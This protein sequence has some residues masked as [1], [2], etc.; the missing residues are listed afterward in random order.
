M[1][2]LY[3]TAIAVAAALTL[4]GCTSTAAVDRDGAAGA[5]TAERS[6]EDGSASGAQ[7]TAAA[8]ESDGTGAAAD[9]AQSGA[10]T[11]ATGTQAAAAGTGSTAATSAQATP[12]AGKG[13]ILNDNCPDNT[14]ARS[15]ELS[16]RATIADY[17]GTLT[18][19][20]TGGSED[21][22]QAATY[23]KCC[24]SIRAAIASGTG[25]ACTLSFSEN[26]DGSGTPVT[27]EADAVPVILDLLAR[28]AAQ[29]YAIYRF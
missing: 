16:L 20:T 23:W 18:F 17:N 25:S 13:A 1:E 28:G 7:D 6:A 3:M 8:E 19:V 27:A 12:T 29:V 22:E 15:A 24:E 2:R 10:G 4:A 21:A 26:A 9:T 14:Y 5:A 11:G